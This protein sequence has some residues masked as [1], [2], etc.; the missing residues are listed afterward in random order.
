MIQEIIIP[1]RNG[2]S[3]ALADSSVIGDGLRTRKMYQ[4]VPSG[5]DFCVVKNS[6]DYNVSRI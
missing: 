6:E 5:N 3:S 4:Q 1:G 2:L